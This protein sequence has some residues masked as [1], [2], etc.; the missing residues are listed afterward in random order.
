M[1]SLR[2]L[3]SSKLSLVERRKIV[4]VPRQEA[5]SELANPGQTFDPQSHTIQEAPLPAVEERAWMG[6]LQRPIGKDNIREWEEV[7]RCWTNFSRQPSRG[8][9]L[10]SN[11]S[12]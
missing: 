2:F 4:L 12:W 1:E 6:S 11:V 10:G 9:V 5:P 8:V 3:G 7:E